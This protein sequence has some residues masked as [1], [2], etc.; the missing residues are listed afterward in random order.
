MVAFIFKGW[1]VVDAYMFHVISIGV[2]SCSWNLV[3]IFGLPIL[4]EDVWGGLRLCGRGIEEVL[5]GRAKKRDKR[6]EGE[7]EGGVA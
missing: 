2:I 4:L 5:E 3:F 1:I 7:R 6:G